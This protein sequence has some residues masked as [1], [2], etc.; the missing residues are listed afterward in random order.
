LNGNELEQRGQINTG[1]RGVGR[2]Y[3]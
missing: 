2:V 1:T 3:Q